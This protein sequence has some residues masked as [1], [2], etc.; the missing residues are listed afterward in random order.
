MRSGGIPFR[1]CRVACCRTLMPLSDRSIRPCRVERAYQQIGSTRPVGVPSVIHTDDDH[2]APLFV[3]SVEHAV[4]PSPGC[5]DTAEFSAQRFTDSSW[6]HDEGRRQEIDH[7]CRHGFGKL[8][9]QCASRRWSE[10][11]FVVVL[12]GHRRRLRTASTPRTTSPLA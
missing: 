11:E 4:G 1:S 3:Q 12:L 5:P 8:V 10:D 6:L 7:C 2:F 9:G